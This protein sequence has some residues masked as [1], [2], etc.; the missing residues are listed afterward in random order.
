MNYIPQSMLIIYTHMFFI[1]LYKLR[2]LPPLI[3]QADKYAFATNQFLFISNIR[4][5]NI[6]TLKLIIAQSLSLV[7]F[8]PSL[9]CSPL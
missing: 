9:D 2:K 7:R 5:S 1:F 8:W 3:S 4:A 6:Y